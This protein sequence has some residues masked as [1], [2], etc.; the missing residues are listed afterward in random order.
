MTRS[1]QYVNINGHIP[2]DVRK[3]IWECQKAKGKK[4]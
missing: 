4:K 2:L 3:M 1:D